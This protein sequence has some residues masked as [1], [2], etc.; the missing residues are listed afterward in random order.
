LKRRL[1]AAANTHIFRPVRR[2]NTAQETS[3]RIPLLLCTL[4]I[5]A[6]ALAQS[7]VENAEH[8]PA[9]E[10]GHAYP[11]FVVLPSAPQSKPKPPKVIDVKFIV[12][13]GILAAAES[14]RYTTRILV[15]EHERQA[16]DPWIGS[17]SPHPQFVA[18]TLAIYFAESVMV[19]ELKKRHEWLPADR[20][21][22]RLWWVYPAIMTQAH[23]RNASGSIHTTG[24]GGC[25]SQQTCQFP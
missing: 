2:Q 13:M 20:V 23:F 24:P 18:K 7:H 5:T 6:F 8:E 4:L 9:S 17:I 10:S 25:T 1:A 12:A 21:I 15:L 14:T 19:Y 16:G 11:A 22:R 3:L